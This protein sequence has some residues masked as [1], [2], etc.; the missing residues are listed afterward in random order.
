MKM[1]LVAATRFEIEPAI[2]FLENQPLHFKEQWEVLITGIGCMITSHAV[3]RHILQSKTELLIQAGIAGSF[4]GS[5]PP[6][7]VVLVAEE[8]MGD[9]GVEEN[10]EFRDVFDMEFL[11]PA[12]HPFSDGALRN[13]G[14]SR[15][16]YLNL[17]LVKGLTVNEITT[18]PGRIAQLKNKYSCETESMEGAAFHYVCLREDIPFLQLRSISNF[19]GER[20]KNNWQLRHSVE[21]LNV[22]LLQLINNHT[23]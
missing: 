8:R 2:A 22:K 19:V 17:P 13:N 9:L 14:I 5:F 15:W 1:T 16:S 11:N 23:P 4:S 6:G 12:Q 18:D 21:E 3:T 10:G 20:D 7:S